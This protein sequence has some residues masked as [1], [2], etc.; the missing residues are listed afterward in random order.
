MTDEASI[1]E[2]TEIARFVTRQDEA[3]PALVHGVMVSR[4][5]AGMVVAQFYHDY[6]EVPAN[7]TVFVDGDG[8][9]TFDDA[10]AEGVRNVAATIVMSPEAAMGVGRSL[11]DFATDTED[12]EE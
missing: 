10:S 12:D 2:R 3:P 7:T 5:A 1:G 6:L 11:V 9:V 4:S 8:R